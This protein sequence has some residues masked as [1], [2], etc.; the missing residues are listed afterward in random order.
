[1]TIIGKWNP[2]FPIYVCL[3][4]V[5]FTDKKLLH[6]HLYSVTKSKRNSDSDYFFHLL[7][8]IQAL[9]KKHC[10]KYDVNTFD[11]LPS[12]FIQITGSSSLEH[13]KQVIIINCKQNW[14]WMFTAIAGKVASESFFSIYTSRFCH[15][16]NI[17]FPD[18]HA[19]RLPWFDIFKDFNMFLGSSI[20]LNN[21]WY[22]S[23]SL[24]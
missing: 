8:P 20:P 9:F 3:E 23:L 22:R 5:N 14:P 6:F 13:T 7:E 16:Q 11:I 2:I 10:K 12:Y 21:R 17:F 1:M 18:G 4:K 24:K 15:F 19:H